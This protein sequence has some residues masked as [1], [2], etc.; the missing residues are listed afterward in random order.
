MNAPEVVGRYEIIEELG[1]GA[2]GSVFKA[3]DPVVGRTV[4][5]K[6]IHSTALNGSQ[7]EEYRTRFYREA[8]ASGVLAHPGI[9]PVFDVGEHQGAPF[10]VMEFVDGRT[11]ADA[12]KKGE[13]F[14]IDRVCEIGQQLAE[15]LGY[16][17]RQG[18]IHRDIKPANILL[19]SREVYGSERPRITDF[20]IAKLAASE[21]TTTGQLLGTPS[22]MPPEQ[23]TGA[24]IDGRADLFSLGVILYSLS[25]GEQPF[26][27]ETMTAVSYKVVYTEPVPPSRLNPAVPATLENVI[28]KCLA[29]NPTARYQSGEE[30]A[31]DLAAIRMNAPAGAAQPVA[32]QV[33]ESDATLG[34]A[35]I[36]APAPALHAK[37]PGA[38]AASSQKPA[39]TPGKALPFETVFAV[40]LL[41]VAGFVA[42]VALGW[43]L[44]AHHRSMV[45][46]EQRQPANPPAAKPA[47]VP[48]QVP[49]PQ[50]ET[51]PALPES[52]APA[53]ENQPPA[54]APATGE[55]QV[56]AN[57][58]LESKPAAKK[59]APGKPSVTAPP[60]A[61]SEPAAAT[62]PAVAKTAAPPP[63]AAAAST[64]NAPAGLGFDPR[65]LDPK[66]NAKMKIDLS[67]LPVGLP[68]V[69]Q[70]NGKVYLR[71]ITGEKTD[72]DNLYVP[73][74][75]QKFQVT[76]KSGGQQK[77]SNTVSQ[78]FKV[79][80]RET[81]KIEL[82]KQTKPPASSAD[83]LGGDAKIVLSLVSGLTVAGL[84]L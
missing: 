50:P 74:G 4:A 63:P 44:I 61:S 56:A 37:M 19:T 11:L 35:P 71:G 58:P 69:V 14:T 13:R 80:K 73:P 12:I 40:V 46:L 7:S 43:V 55:K 31:R 68:Y 59:P 23:F 36:A 66:T 78:E 48:Q 32:P 49:Q 2:M 34:L 41:T 76:M 79:K 8:R 27:G 42:I 5:L 16:A 64:P 83:P 70:M 9:V 72:L 25:T 10:L 82:T 52:A 20:G 45:A 24:P 15:A 21:I 47:A 3:R 29:K 33:A 60:P 26:P 62:P 54:P 28:L 77:A 30:V 53:V 39:K 18:V 57:A 51:P 67:H 75:T 81:L 17:H 1:R 6:T 84:H 38:T 65:K 22:F